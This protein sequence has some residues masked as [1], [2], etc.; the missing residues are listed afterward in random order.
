MPALG[1]D[2]VMASDPGVIG[3]IKQVSPGMEIHL[4]TQANCTNYKSALFWHGVGVKRIV[5]ARELSLE[6]IKVL[7]EAA[8][9]LRN[10]GVCPR[11]DVRFVFGQVPFVGLHDRQEF[12]PG[13]CAQPCRYKYYL[14]EEKGPVSIIKLRRRAGVRIYLTQRICV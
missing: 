7:E 1:A 11:L 8:L 2:A 13:E 14:V 4:S 3:T 5:A 12:K 9:K 10:R 6:E